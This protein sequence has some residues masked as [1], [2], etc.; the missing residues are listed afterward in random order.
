MSIPND[1]GNLPT[2]EQSIYG[3]VGRISKSKVH[4]YLQNKKVGT[5]LIRKSR[6]YPFLFYIMIK[7][8]AIVISIPIAIVKQDGK[9]YGIKIYYD[10]YKGEINNSFY[11]PRVMTMTKNFKTFMD[12]LQETTGSSANLLNVLH[13]HLNS[14]LKLNPIRL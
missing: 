12:I 7:F 14:D 3:Y 6:V 10:S 1:F 11:E 5:Y 13:T 8:Q 9:I 4:E 2:S